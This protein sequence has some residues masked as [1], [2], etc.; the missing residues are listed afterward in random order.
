LQLSGPADNNAQG[1]AIAFSA[2]AANAANSGLSY[3]WDF[4]DG[5]SSN[6]AAPSH[7]YAKAGRYTVQ[8]TVTNEA[9]TSRAASATVYVADFDIVRGKQCSGAGNTGWCWQRPLPQGN[10]LNAYFFLDDNR[11]WAVGEL[12]TVLT[13]NDGGATWTR[14]SADTQL[15]LSDVTFVNAQ[16]GWIIAANG[17]VLK[18]TDGG[19]SWSLGSTG[20]VNGIARLAASDASTAWVA[21]TYGEMAATVDGGQTWN[22]VNPGSAFYQYSVIVGPTTV[23]TLDGDHV[24]R[25]LD[26]LQ[27]TAFT[28]PA[29][30]S[31]LYRYVYGLRA[32]DAQHAWISANESGSVNNVYTSRTLLYRTRDG[33]LTWDRFDGTGIQYASVVRFFDAD[34]GY[35][36]SYY[37]GAVLRTTDGGASW[38]PVT[39]PSQLSAYGGQFTAFSAGQLGIRDSNGRFFRSSDGGATW[40]ERSSGTGNSPTPTGL[41][42]FDARDGLATTAD[43]GM[44]RTTDGG[45]TW[46]LT[47]SQT[48]VGWRRPQFLANGTGWV[49]SDTGVIYRSADKGRTWFAPAAQNSPQI[50]GL[51]DFHFV[52]DLHGWAVSQYPW[53][54]GSA[55]FRS[56]DGG[57][58][59]KPVPGTAGW[60]GLLSV[61]FADTTHGVAVGPA[62]TALVTAD[63]GITWA[64]RGANTT[65]T[66]RRVTFADANTVVAVGDYG[67][68]VRSTDR[69][70]T[71]SQAVSGTW[72]GLQEVRF[73]SPR[74]GWA[75]GDAG[76]VLV[77]HDGGASWTRQSTLASTGLA[78]A[79]F[80]DEQTGWVTGNSGAILA[81]ATGGR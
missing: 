15:P 55:V 54:S 81:T 50:Y 79:F 56:D 27:W 3:R 32:I 41:W 23:W 22:R 2:N 4:G 31:G 52:D 60:I 25:T 69:G 43:G 14:Q 40:V 76:T 63:G 6:E 10:A 9:G 34:N 51:A 68:I 61:R 64:P 39:L 20:I 16:V 30:E 13:T 72:V 62:G 67:T 77:T 65:A 58:S 73:A 35:A 36:W 46:T 24:L 26:G 37:G 47:P 42:F 38:Q 33:G 70:Q 19:S 59:W 28:L 49:M 45:Q 7:A 29:P 80:L 1:T 44:L 21:G 17:Q 8:L 57:G 74:I 75:M 12:G 53:N 18:T 48:Q 71:W 5:S 11:G 66:L 78:N